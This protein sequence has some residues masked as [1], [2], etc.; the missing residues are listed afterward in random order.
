[1]EILAASAAAAEQQ[2]NE[3]KDEGQ[4][5]TAPISAFMPLVT[6]V[7][8]L[9]QGS[10]WRVGHYMPRGTALRRSWRNVKVKLTRRAGTAARQV[11]SAAAEEARDEGQ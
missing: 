10:Q 5:A 4:A 9:S 1:M 6:V 11:G 7:C 8:L 2:L 3:A